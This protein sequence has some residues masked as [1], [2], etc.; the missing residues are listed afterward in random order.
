MTNIRSFAWEGDKAD[1]G[2]GVVGMLGE[3]GGECAG[4][5]VAT[6]EDGAAAEVGEERSAGE[7]RVGEGAPEVQ[8]D[9][10]AGEGEQG[11]EAGDGRVEFEDERDAEIGGEPEGGAFEDGVEALITT[12]KESGVVETELR[13]GGDEQRDADEQ[14]RKVGRE[15]CIRNVDT[16]AA[17][18]RFVAK[19]PAEKEAGERDGGVAGEQRE[20][21]D[22]VAKRIVRTAH[23]G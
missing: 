14:E 12:E 4:I 10:D 23:E 21:N 20:G 2:E 15:R 8:E 17:E 19:E 3:F 1:E 7:D 5:V 18:R 13:E 22:G 16:E 6:E 9:D 11:E